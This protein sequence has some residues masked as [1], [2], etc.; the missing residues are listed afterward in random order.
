MVRR[1]GQADCRP[2]VRAVDEQCLHATVAFLL[3]LAQG[4]AGEQLRLGERLR[5]DL[6]RVVGEQLANNCGCV[7]VCGLNLCE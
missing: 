2:K 5:A 4:Q 7:N 1:M 3:V 6:V